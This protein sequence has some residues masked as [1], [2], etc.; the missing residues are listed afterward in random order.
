M[1]R[2]VSKIV[3]YLSFLSWAFILLLG[4]YG[5]V[6][7]LSFFHMCYG[8][9]GFCVG[10]ISGTFILSVVPVFPACLVY[11]IAYV[12]WKKV[13]AVRKLSVMNYIKIAV[14]LGVLFMVAVLSMFF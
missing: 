13:P 3:F 1:K 4:V 6:F 14:I 10:V 8:W 2:N 12:L 5:A 7:G 9:D 11:E